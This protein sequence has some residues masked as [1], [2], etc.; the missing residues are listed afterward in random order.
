MSASFRVCIDVDDLERAIAFYTQVF[1]L[2]LGRRGGQDWAELLGGSAPIDLLAKSGGTMAFS[3]H[4]AKRD[5]ARH[6]TPLHLDFEVTELDAAVERALAAGAKLESP[7]T[8]KPWG[9]IALF[10]DPFGHGFCLLEMN[11]RG[12]DALV[13]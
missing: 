4:G 9:R 8:E 13:E 10:S 7:A 1:G 5:Y 11:E 12:Y 2:T 3:P 6:W